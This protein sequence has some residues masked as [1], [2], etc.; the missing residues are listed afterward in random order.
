[1][2]RRTARY[3]DRSPV[4]IATA[5][6]LWSRFW[7]GAIALAAFYLIVGLFLTYWWVALTAIVVCLLVYLPMRLRAEQRAR[8]RK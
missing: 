4:L 2:T 8:E 5:F 1:M 6:G 3:Q 7:L